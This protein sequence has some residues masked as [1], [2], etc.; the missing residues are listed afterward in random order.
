MCRMHVINLHIQSTTEQMAETS[1]CHNSK[2]R[3]AKEHFASKKSAHNI[4]YFFYLFIQLVSAMFQW[5]R[6]Q[7]DSISDLLV[8]NWVAIVIYLYANVQYIQQ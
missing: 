4:Y 6:S 5:I 8:F 3:N 7:N 2:D 1:V